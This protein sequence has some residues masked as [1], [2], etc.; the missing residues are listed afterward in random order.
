MS[1]VCHSQCEPKISQKHIVRRVQKVGQV[2]DGVCLS[3]KVPSNIYQRVVLREKTDMEIVKR[4]KK[5]T[6]SQYQGYAKQ[7][8]VR[9]DLVG[10]LNN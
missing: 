8:S 5:N 7:H 3:L 9:L 10:C 1:S 2:C 6:L 4:K